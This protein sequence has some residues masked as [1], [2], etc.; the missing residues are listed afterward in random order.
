MYET[1]IM[2]VNTSGSYSSNIFPVELKRLLELSVFRACGGKV[3][4]DLARLCALGVDMKTRVNLG[5]LA[6]LVPT[7]G[8]NNND[9]YSRD[10]DRTTWALTR[11]APGH[12]TSWPGV[13]ETLPW[14]PR[15]L[16]GGASD[17]TTLE[18]GSVVDV[19]FPA[20]LRWYSSMLDCTSLH[21]GQWMRSRMARPPLHQYHHHHDRQGR[22]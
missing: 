2:K 17:G 7:A 19:N 22:P 11:K 4:V 13:E 15:S 5:Q 9:E 3:G 18:E 12:E 6:A 8:K 14:S 20:R 16:L 1:K 21:G 10:R